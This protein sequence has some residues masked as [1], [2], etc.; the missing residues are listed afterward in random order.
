MNQPRCPAH[1]YHRDGNMRSADNT[2]SAI[3]YEPNNLGGPVESYRFKQRPPKLHGDTDRHD[4]QAGNDDC[5]RSGD[6]F[7]LTKVEQKWGPFPD[8]SKQ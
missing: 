8:T 7:R 5:T 4:H 1:T 2:G 3:N 6:L